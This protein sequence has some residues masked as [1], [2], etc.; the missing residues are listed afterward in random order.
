VIHSW[1]IPIQAVMDGRNCGGGN[2]FFL[3]DKV[4]RCGKTVA[5][6]IKTII[7]SL[8]C[9]SVQS[10]IVFGDAGSVTFVGKEGPGRGRNLVLIAGDEEYRSED[11]MPM[12]GKILSQKHGFTCTVLFSVSPEGWID[13]NAQASLTHP[14]SLDSA[15]AIIMLV[16]F[17]K[18]SDEAMKHFDDAMRRGVPVIGLRTSTHAFQLPATSSFKRYNSFGKD[19]LGEKWVNHWGRHKS[20]ATRGVIEAANAADPILRGV[21]DVFGD[22]DVYEAAP[23]ADA[24]ILMRGQVLSGMKPGDGPANYPKKRANGQ[25]QP[26]NDPMMP[27]V[28]TREL[29][30]ESGRI[31]KIFCTTMGAATDMASEDLRRVVVNG[32]YWSL[33]IDVPAKADVTPIGDFKPLMYGN[34]GFHPKVKPASHGM[35]AEAK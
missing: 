20:E 31:Q 26:I 10:A 24:K 3:K 16:R 23:P 17:R 19:V 11:V 28:W 32:V 25:E 6:S 9:L 1:E 7:L 14:E 2:R 35:A 33:G 21:S 29:K 13:P 18:W 15:D 34:N 12:L 5:V 22:S 27:I 4:I 30:N 8:L